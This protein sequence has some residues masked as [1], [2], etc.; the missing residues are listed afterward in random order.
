M[1][2]P[3]RCGKCSACQLVEASKA[4]LMPNPPFEHA[5]NRTVECWN[6]VLRDNPC[7]KSKPKEQEQ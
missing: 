4:L 1:T 3:V 2:M 7:E 6:K 5:D